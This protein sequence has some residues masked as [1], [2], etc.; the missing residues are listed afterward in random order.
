MTSRGIAKVLAAACL[1]SCLL[2]SWTSLGCR[3]GRS[4]PSGPASSAVAAQ[5]EARPTVLL[6]AGERVIPIR[7]ELAR[8]EPERER[9][10]MFRNHLDPDAGM[11]FLFP[12]P[13][14]LT[15]WMKNTFVPLDMVFIDEN[16]RVLGI[17]ENAVPETEVPRR[18]PGESQFVLEV[19]G[20]LTRQ[21]GIS[22]GTPV[23]FRDIKLDE[24]TN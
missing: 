14:P 2:G 17:V 11:L 4:D 7:V 18:V 24:I 16:K 9:G 21:L 3:N 6:H 22:A 23:D 8:T 13:G 5:V 20:G 12:R 1:G 15:F 10:L 19:V